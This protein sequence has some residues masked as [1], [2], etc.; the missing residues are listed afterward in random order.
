MTDGTPN[1]PPGCWLSASST[2]SKPTTPS[3]SP[4]ESPRAWGGALQGRKEPIAGPALVDMRFRRRRAD[5]R[6]ERLH[7]GREDKLPTAAAEDRRHCSPVRLKSHGA[8]RGGLGVA[9]G[10]RQYG[11]A[12][13][14]GDPGGED[15]GSG[16]GAENFVPRP[17]HGG[18]RGRGGARQELQYRVQAGGQQGPGGVG[19]T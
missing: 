5:G 1:S 14:D 2:R 13:D 10:D 6:D 16:G 4:A 7:D 11:G 17:P 9:T 8:A 3:M 19:S 18:E 15:Q 12:E